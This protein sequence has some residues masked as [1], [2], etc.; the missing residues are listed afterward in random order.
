MNS[1]PII[2]PEGKKKILEE[3]RYLT[4][5]RRKEIAD[6]IEQAKGLGDLSENAEYASA[7]EEQAFAEGKILELEEL[8]KTAL[9]VQLASSDQTVVGLGTN[10]IVEANGKEITI[11]IVGA[12]ESNMAEGKISNESPIGQSLLGAKLHE[13]VK[14]STPT[15]VVHYTVKKIIS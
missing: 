9:F 12:N 5:V 7:R 14:V 4:K 8:L 13:V 11:Q 1:Q 10:V 2:T 15:G 6:R 3:L